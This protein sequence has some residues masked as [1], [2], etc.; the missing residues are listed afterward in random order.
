MNWRHRCRPPYIG[1]LAGPDRQAI[2][3]GGLDQWLTIR[4]M[5][6]MSQQ[7]GGACRSASASTSAR[8]IANGV[9]SSCAASARILPA[10]RSHVQ[11]CSA[12]IDRTHQRPA[13][14]AAS[15]P[16][17]AGYRCARPDLLRQG[18]RFSTDAAPCG[19]QQVDCPAA[20][21]G[22]HDH[23]GHVRQELGH[24][25]S[26]STSRCAGPARSAPTAFR[27]RPSPARWRRRS[28]TFRRRAPIAGLRS[29]FLRGT[30][31]RPASRDEKQHAPLRVNTAKP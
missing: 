12:S 27:H 25:S 3:F 2:E 8:R 23:P 17:A 21:A 16:P 31:L 14:H 26:I 4:V 5:P 29:E 15:R 22:S 11:P 28:A 19:D 18:G 24:V 7:L 9:R 1:D 10:P 20:P 30:R 13:R 6:A